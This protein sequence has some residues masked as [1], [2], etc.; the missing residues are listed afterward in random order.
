MRNINTADYWNNRFGSGDWEDRGGRSQT[1]QFA[2]AQIG[3]LQVGRDFQGLLCDF[4]CGAGDAFPIYRDAFPNARLVGVDFAAPAINLCLEK[5]GEF[6]SFI[7]GDVDSVPESDLIVS[8]NVLEH[9]DDDLGVIDRLRGRCRR[10]IVVV[11]YNERPLHEEH[12]RSY[13]RDAFDLLDP[14]RKEVFLS[15]GWSE[16]G[17]SLV[18]KIYF[19]NAAR[20]LT[21]KP[22]ATRGRQLLVEFRGRI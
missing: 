12:V 13:G 5:Y 16:Y 22:T 9:L 14:V 18:K 10:L 21:G 1:R 2:I 7:C 6:A 8:S 17:F 4:G 20:W 3:R 11:P 15:P 19:G